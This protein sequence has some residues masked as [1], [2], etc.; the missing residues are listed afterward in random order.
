MKKI[1]TI[2]IFFGALTLSAQTKKTTHIQTNVPNLGFLIY[3]EVVKTAAGKTF[4]KKLKETAGDESL[5]NSIVYDDGINI[6]EICI[7][8]DCM[9][10]RVVKSYFEDAKKKNIIVELIRKEQ[11]PV[12]LIVPVNREKI[13]MKT[14]QKTRVFLGDDIEFIESEQGI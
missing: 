5:K 14:A 3:S 11:P 8:G 6:M 13:I 10:Y 2:A 4:E 1:Y 12:T 9:T 7:E